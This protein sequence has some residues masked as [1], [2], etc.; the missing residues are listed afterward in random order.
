VYTSPAYP[1]R[2]DLGHTGRNMVTK[3]PRCGPIQPAQPLRKLRSARYVCDVL[4][5]SGNTLKRLRQAGKIRA[6]RVGGSV[7][8]DDDEIESVQRNGTSQVQ[9][10]GNPESGKGLT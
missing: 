7:R 10:G 6:V 2:A 9:E 3:E 1:S 5:I 4:G 8:F